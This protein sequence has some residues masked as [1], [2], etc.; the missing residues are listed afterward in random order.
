[1]SLDQAGH[2]SLL[3]VI[4]DFLAGVAASPEDVTDEVLKLAQV[5]VGSKSPWS[6][7]Q[8]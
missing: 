8:C 2:A 5:A 7:T 1:M 4:E 3:T 6:N